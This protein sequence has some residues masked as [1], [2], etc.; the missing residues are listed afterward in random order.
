MGTAFVI[1]LEPKT[2]TLKKIGAISTLTFRCLSGPYVQSFME[3]LPNTR[4]FIMSPLLFC[5]NYQFYPF[6]NKTFCFFLVI[7]HSKFPSLLTLLPENRLKNS[8]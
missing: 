3:I 2:A 6:T 5:I 4:T 1:F 7:G 8:Y